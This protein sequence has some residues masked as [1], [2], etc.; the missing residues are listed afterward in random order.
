MCLNHCVHYAKLLCGSLIANHYHS[1]SDILGDSHLDALPDADARVDTDDYT[2]AHKDADTDAYT[3]AHTHNDAYV[4]A[5]GVAHARNGAHALV[6]AHNHARAD[7]G[8]GALKVLPRA[9]RYLD[10]LSSSRYRD[11][12]SPYLDRSSSYL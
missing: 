11:R 9:A 1:G 10:S 6:D 12:S 8:V 3:D 5:H 4:C 7:F 2:D